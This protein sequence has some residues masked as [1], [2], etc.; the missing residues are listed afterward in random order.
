MK[1]VQNQNKNINITNKC[2]DSYFQNI[3]RTGPSLKDLCRF[4]PPKL[5]LPFQ[6]EEDIRNLKSYGAAQLGLVCVH[7]RMGNTRINKTEHYNI[8]PGDQGGPFP[9]T[10]QFTEMTSLPVMA[11]IMSGQVKPSGLNVNK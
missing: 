5:K 11:R 8:R 6:N 7:L 3:S 10:R 4:P 2:E 1:V 9:D